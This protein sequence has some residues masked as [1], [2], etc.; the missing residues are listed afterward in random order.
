MLVLLVSAITW[1][2][3]TKEKAAIPLTKKEIK[4]QVD[5][6]MAGKNKAIIESASR[7]LQYR[8]KIEVKGKADS[9]VKM[10]GRPDTTT[11]APKI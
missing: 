5:S 2:S 6:I 11:K 1:T 8:L 7:D 10:H 9:L 3:C 4:K